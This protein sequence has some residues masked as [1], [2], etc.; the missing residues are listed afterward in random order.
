MYG[1]CALLQLRFYTLSCVCL[2]AHLLLSGHAPYLSR[3]DDFWMLAATHKYRGR[4]TLLLS[5]FANK[6]K[7]L[8]TF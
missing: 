4:N 8:H 1:A 6:I 2:D 7:L 5:L 3:G